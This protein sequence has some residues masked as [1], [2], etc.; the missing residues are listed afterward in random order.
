MCFMDQLFVWPTI[1]Q[2]IDED[3]IKQHYP[4]ENE[5]QKK[6]LAAM[7]SEGATNLDNLLT[8]NFAVWGSA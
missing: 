7:L 5:D 3:K 1:A 4:R 2:I 8:Q 6:L